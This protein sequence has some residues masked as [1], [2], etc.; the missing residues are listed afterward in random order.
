V[1]IKA[2]NRPDAI[3]WGI[4]TLVSL[5]FLW[6][7][8]LMLVGSAYQA[9]VSLMKERARET[10]GHLQATIPHLAPPE[11]QAYLQEFARATPALSYLLIMDATG[12]AVAHSNPARVG[13]NFDEPGFRQCLKSGKMIEQTYLRDPGNPASPFHNEKTLDLQAPLRAASGDILGVVDVGLSLAAIERVRKEYR[14]ISLIGI[15]IWLVLI[16]TFVLLH[17]S[18]ERRRARADQLRQESEERFRTL[19]E[20]ASDAIFIMERGRIVDCNQKMLS[21]FR[22]ARKAELLGERL[23]AFSPCRQPEGLCSDEKARLKINAALSGKSQFYT[24]RHK[25]RDGSEFD[26]EVSLQAFE[27]HGKAYLHAIV[28]DVT[29]HNQAQEERERLMSAIQQAAESI[30]IADAA[31]AIQYANPAFERITGHTQAEAVGRTL[32]VLSRDEHDAALVR[33]VRETLDAGHPW[34]GRIVGRHKDGSTFT[35]DAVISPVR[36]GSGEIVNLVAVKRDVTHEIALEQQLCE[37]QKMEAIGQVTG[38]VAHDFNNMLQVING[39]TQMVLAHPGL[40]ETSR[41]HLQQV[42]LAGDRAAT[43]VSQLLTFSRR[44]IMRPEPL[45]LNTVINDFLKMLRRVIGEHIRL[46]HR[47][48]EALAA[49]H[50]DRGMMEQVLMNLCVNARD[51]MPD[52]GELVIATANLTLDATGCENRPGSRPGRYVALEVGDTGC[53]MAQETLERIYEPFFTTKG[54]GKG[55]GLG[56][57]T[58]YGIVKQHQGIIEVESAVGRGTGFKIYL[59][60]CGEAD[61]SPAA[62]LPPEPEAPR[63]RGRET[64]LLAEDDD[65]V[66]ELAGEV[67]EDAGYTLLRAR[68][69]AEAVELFREHSG[70]VALLILD[71]MMP[72]LGGRDACEAIRALRPDVPALFVSG[73]SQ[74]TIHTDFMLDQGLMWLQKPFTPDALLRKVRQALDA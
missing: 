71:V 52:G 61:E 1:K 66:R 28:R 50:A 47:P 19:F 42:K 24:W 63:P 73:Y 6:G 9:H 60:C 64:L 16:L 22:Y 32:S 31:G 13:M 5:L 41:G 56:L 54:A 8:I 55:T 23:T 45:D 27:L 3:L 57:S 26:A 62:G 38:G 51:A 33:Q 35:E 25:R 43:L 29:E 30:V 18:N 74:G 67:L 20:S 15:A 2:V 12:T 59:P 14:T 39:F 70:R 49:V 37:A 7:F 44:R 68:D 34:R 40:D 36:D 21:M 65:L 58:V 17:L 69:G 48:A 53:G 72:N 11:R 10:I 46:T 4:I